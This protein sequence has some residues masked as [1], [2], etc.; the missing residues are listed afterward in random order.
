MEKNLFWDEREMVR[1]EGPTPTT[2][3]PFPTILALG[4]SW[5]WYPFPNANLLF[6]LAELM[7]HQRILAKGMNGAELQQFVEGKYKGIVNEAL[8]R[9]RGDLKAVLISGGGNDFAGFEDLRPL[10]H[11]D[12]A[13][14]ATPE[15]CFNGL[16]KFLEDIGGWYERLIA[17]IQQRAGPDCKILL[18]T[19]DYALPTGKGLFGNRSWLREALVH[20]GV[21]EHLRED[22]I[23]HL[24]QQFHEAIDGVARKHEHRVF[25]V[26]SKG[27][28]EA[29][30]WDN[31]L[32][33]TARGFQKIVQR[34][35]APVLAQAGLL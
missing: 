6:P 32:H 3:S 9:Y 34:A 24:I 15:S 23:V 35:W 26:D 14:M 17:N 22:C 10:L 4:D 30:D 8:R 20:A 18:H 16:D 27:V 11:D 5:F 21:P 33:P 1:N 31:E 28:L 19:Y 2:G 25:V 7:P 29:A 12:C 13:R